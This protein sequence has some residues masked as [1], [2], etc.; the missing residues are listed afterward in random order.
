MI[1]LTSLV[2]VVLAIL[3]IGAVFALLFWLT[4]YVERQFPEPPMPT[5]CK[6]AR[7]ALVVIGVVV[8]IFFLIGLVSGRPMFTVGGG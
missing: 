7:V 4:H 6:I 3:I 5:A 8:L 1:D 2:W